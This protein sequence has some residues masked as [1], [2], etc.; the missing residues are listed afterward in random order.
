MLALYALMVVSGA[1]AEVREVTVDPLT[2]TEHWQVGGS[3]VNYTLGSSALEPAIEPRREG[4]EGSLRLTAD[5]RDAQRYYLSAYHTG[6]AIRGVCQSV[7][8]WV[9]GD[10]SGRRLQMEL[11]DARGRWFRQDVGRLDTTEWQQLAAPIGE[12]EGWS[13]LLRIGESRLPI[14]H[15]VNLRQI[16]VL[17]HGGAEPMCTLYLSDLRATCDVAP[18]DDLDCGIA[19]ERPNRLFDRSKGAFALWMNN[20]GRA[21]LPTTWRWEVR[22]WDG[23]VR[24]RGSRETTFEPGKAQEEP[25]ELRDLPAGPYQVFVEA[26]TPERTREWSFRFA[27]LDALPERPAEPEALFGSMFNVGGFRADEASTVARL[28]RDGGLRWT[29]VGFGWGEINPSPG[30]WAWD[31]PERLEGPVGQAVDL[32]GSVYQLPD[33]PILSCPDAVTIAFWARGTEHTGNWQFPLM[34]W[35]S[36]PRNY[37]VYFHRDTGRLTFSATYDDTPVGGWQDTSCDFSAWDGQWHHYAASYSAADREVN[38]YVDGRV[39]ASVEHDGGQLWTNTDPLTLGSGCPAPLDEVVLY[40]RALSLDEVGQLAAK[41]QPPEEGLIAH[42]AFE[43]A[44][45]ALTDSS[46]HGLD[47]APG[48]PAGV[49]EAR[50]AL[51]QGMKTLGLLGFPP[52]WASTAPEGAERPWVYK[53]KLDAW[54]AFVEQTT[55]HYADLVQHWEIWNEPNITVFWEP[56]PDPREFMDVLRVGYEAAKRGN[57]D[58]TVLMPGLAGPTENRWGMDFLDELLRLGAARY[59]DAISIHPYRQTTPEESDLVGDLQHIADL[60]EANGG[61]RL[62]WFTENCW[63]TQ[64]PGGSTEDRQAQAL[65]R[66]YVLSLSTGLMGKLLWFRLHDAGPDRF[67]SEHNYGLCYEDLTPKPAYFAHRTVAQVLEGAQPVGEWDVGP[68]ALGRVFRTPTERVAAV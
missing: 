22:A 62:I 48:E 5:F 64:I 35:G 42:W 28:N 41:A 46:G 9:R 2:S 7:S 38:L 12:G 17:S 47:F 56:T 33:Q 8:V 44:G 21:P 32:K 36:G 67:Y 68:H 6:P 20:A 13:P 50:E 25:V 16:A 58:C 63:T 30:V 27:V 37:G 43:E 26:E 23:T 19:A 3:R 39:Q 60:A 18:A 29:R 65:P 31:G 54:A 61:R 1:S 40:D 51:K 57:P 34:K 55:R 45:P 4:T 59:C 10:G 52:D 11:E 49:R 53:P 24:D 15:P 66:C 14:L